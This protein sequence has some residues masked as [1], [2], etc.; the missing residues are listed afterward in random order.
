MLNSAPSQMHLKSTASWEEA[1]DQSVYS[2]LQA[3]IKLRY[4]L[5]QRKLNH[6]QQL[7]ASNMGN[8][9][10][11]RKGRGMTF[12]EVR[13]YQPGDDIRHI[14]W[15]V[16]ART[17]KVHTKVF[18]EEHE[19]PTF[20]V[21]EQTPALFFGSQKRL[22]TTQVLNIASILAWCSLNQNERVG[23][24]SFNSQQNLFISP[25]RSQKSVLALLLQSIQLQQQLNQPG[26]AQSHYW[27]KTLQQ[28]S[29]TAKPGAKVFLIGDMFQMLDS[30]Y[31]SLRSLQRHLDIVA[32]HVVDT[33]EK[34][35]PELG[36]LSITRAFG[37]NP[38]RLDSFRQKTRQQ[39]AQNYQQTWLKHKAELNK[40]Q[41]P[42]VEINSQQNP[43]QQLLEKRL[44]V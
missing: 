5:K 29:K 38:L 30:G 17:Q 9:H 39:Y 40:L 4:Q 16:T 44:I 18:V 28:L 1:D 14:D 42:L 37:D 7:L 2:N 43:I 13:Q 24:I 26:S 21:C 34:E 10:A 6:Q 41:I 15:R 3:L 8:H 20:L 19:R 23:G 27:P 22:K 25:K 35:L 36:W 12:S 33:L 31:Q 32:I 11:T